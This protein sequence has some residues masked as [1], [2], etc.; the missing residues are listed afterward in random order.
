MDNMKTG[1]LLLNAE[2]LWSSWSTVDTD[3]GGDREAQ[4]NPKSLDG[5]GP[6]KA[7]SSCLTCSVCLCLL[8][9]GGEEPQLLPLQSHGSTVLC[10]FS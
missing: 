10:F 9:Q 7:S 3:G 2:R 1:R 4:L 8:E 5:R 6:P